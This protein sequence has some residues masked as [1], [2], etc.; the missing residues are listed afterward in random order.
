MKKNKYDIFLTLKK[1]K[2]NKLLNNLATLN[3]EKKRLDFIKETLN[4]M[5]N[6][7]SIDK[8]SEL[9]GSDLKF[10]ASFTGN[11]IDK[12]EVSKN[13][14]NHVLDEISNN[15]KEIVRIKKQKEKI[16]EKKKFIK[17]QE[18]KLK[19]LKKENYFKPKNSVSL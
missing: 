16:T 3:D 5:L 14:E 18:E 8:S 1:L 4:E 15:L 9:S 10:R 7:S 19:E 2:K 13:R 11:L 6:H 12:L 17:I